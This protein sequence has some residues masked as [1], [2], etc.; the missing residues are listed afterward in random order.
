MFIGEY[1]HSLDTKG[2][3]TVPV[4]FREELGDVFYITKGLDNCLSVYSA[5]EWE[6]FQ[7]NLNSNRQAKKDFRRIQRFFMSSAYECTLDKQGR[8]L[9]SQTLRDYAGIDK[10][11]AVI[12]VTNRV[13]IWDRERWCGYINDEELDISDLTE[14]IEDLN[15]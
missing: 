12:G 11:V 5:E 8:I 6:K 7:I 10:E 2:R 1:N 9:I 13:E 3:V 15:I 14:S 4:K